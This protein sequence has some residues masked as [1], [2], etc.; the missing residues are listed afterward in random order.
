MSFQMSDADIADSIFKRLVD[1]FGDDLEPSKLP[2]PQQ[3]V[4]LVYHTH[5]ILGN[6]GFQY[7]FEADLPG[8]PEYLLTRAAFQAIAAPDACRAFDIAFQV[9]PNSTPPEDIEARLALWQEHYQLR[10]AL[11]DEES[12]DAIY[13]SAMDEVVEKLT[14][15]I[16]AHEDDFD[17]LR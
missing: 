13:F 2:K 8:D 9:F 12:P 15:Y 16:R 11:E 17:S 1:K 7:L 10:D 6:G 14:E 4:L 3:V 5:G